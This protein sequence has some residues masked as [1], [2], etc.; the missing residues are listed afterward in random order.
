LH[1]KGQ[2]N[3]DLITMLTL[4]ILFA[5]Q[6]TT[7]S[8]MACLDSVLDP[9]LTSDL[10]VAGVQQEGTAVFGS[11][12]QLVFLNGPRTG[13]LRVGE[14]ERVVRPEGKIRDPFTDSELGIYYRDL[15]TI[16]I[17]AVEGGTATA[18]VIMSCKEILK[19]DL[20]RPYVAKSAV[21]FTGAMSDALTPVPEHGLA[22][23]ILVGKDDLRELG[24]G[25]FCFVALGGRDGIKTGDRFTVF[26]PYPPFDPHDLIMSQTEQNSS[27]GSMGNQASRYMG[28]LRLQGRTL[29]P[30][31]LGDIVIVETSD[32]VSFGKIINSM[33]EI[34]PGDFVVK[35]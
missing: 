21:Q 34:H 23:Q 16:R 5:L 11:Q 12:G 25:D 18:R 4:M 2:E 22:G 17:E 32:K 30:R 27:Y 1:I 10:Y 15:G 3:A 20:V 7:P 29:P 33:T 19:G 13:L 28:S 26:R 31:I 24:A 35:R 6:V 9:P 8:E 14:M